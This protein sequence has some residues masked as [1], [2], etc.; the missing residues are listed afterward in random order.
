MNFDSLMGKNAE[1]YFCLVC[2]DQPPWRAEEVKACPTCNSTDDVAMAQRF[3]NL[4]TEN[5]GRVRH[6]D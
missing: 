3:Q 1:V 6:V 5:D 2:D 4:T